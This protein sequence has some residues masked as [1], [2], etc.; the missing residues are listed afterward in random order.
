M[1]YRWAFAVLAFDLLLWF[2]D[3]E[4][5]VLIAKQSASGFGEMLLVVPP[6][7][8][9]I[10]LMDVWVPREQVMAHVGAGTGL[11]GLTLSV[12]LGAA[13]AGPLYGAF[14][15]AGVMLKKGAGFFNVMVFMGSWATLK[16]PM[17]LFEFQYLGHSFA[18]TRWI[19]SLA[20][21]IAIA[22]LLDR[23]TP[24]YEKEDMYDKHRSGAV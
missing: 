8:L 6:I 2:L 15:I 19:C 13:S 20:G 14:P 18:V 21:I 17:F 1:R 23:F 22:F 16:L 24:A 5:G 9:L 4:L 11:R 12:V 3:R 10:G 7:F